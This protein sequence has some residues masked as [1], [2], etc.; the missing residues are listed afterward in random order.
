VPGEDEAA[1]NLAV[2]CV[3]RANDPNLTN[4]LVKFLVGDRD[5]VPKVYLV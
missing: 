4:E 3:G 2:D 5:G 1:I